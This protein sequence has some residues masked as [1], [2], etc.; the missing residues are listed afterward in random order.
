MTLVAPSDAPLLLYCKWKEERTKGEAF[1]LTAAAWNAR[2]GFSHETP[3]L[4]AEVVSAERVQSS[5]VRIFRVAV[6]PRVYERSE[7]AAKITAEVIAAMVVCHE[8]LLEVRAELG[9]TKAG[10]KR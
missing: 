9:L 10:K 6:S 1:G 8:A 2:L 7:M 5:G 4:L 3:A